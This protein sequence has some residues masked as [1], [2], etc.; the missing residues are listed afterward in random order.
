MIFG[1]LS[2]VET[3]L[4]SVRVGGRHFALLGASY[5]H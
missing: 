4:E 5:C 1:L 2:E 3:T